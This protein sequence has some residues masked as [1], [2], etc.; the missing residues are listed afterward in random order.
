MTKLSIISQ[1]IAARYARRQASSEQASTHVQ[2][3]PVFGMLARKTL[4][5]EGANIEQSDDS[6]SSLVKSKL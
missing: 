3:F 4:E 2:L 1:G 6:E 5:R